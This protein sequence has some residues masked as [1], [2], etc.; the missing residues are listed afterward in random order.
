[1]AERLSNQAVEFPYE[2]HLR[3][4]EQPRSTRILNEVSLGFLTLLT[5]YSQ[6]FATP[7][8][9]RLKISLYS[10]IPSLD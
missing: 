6:G 9:E 8:T 4:H 1:M 7:S 10:L 2:I 3:M 5:K